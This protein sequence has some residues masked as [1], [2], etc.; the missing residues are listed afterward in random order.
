MEFYGFAFLVRMVVAT[1]RG[2]G[3]EPNQH[4][5][6]SSNFYNIYYGIRAM[7]QIISTSTL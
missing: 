3:Y 1:N 6:M 5:T 7:V 4:D 2:R